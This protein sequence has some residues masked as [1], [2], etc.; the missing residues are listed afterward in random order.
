MGDEMMENNSNDRNN[1]EI[2]ID[3]VELYGELKKNIKFIFGVTAAC[4]AAAAI[5][6]F[7]IAKPVYGYTTIIQMPAVVSSL[8]INGFVEV[9][10]DDIDPENKALNKLVKAEVPRNTSVIKIYFEG[11]SNEKV[12]AFANAYMQKVMSNINDSIIERQKQQ[13]AVEEIKVIKEEINYINSRLRESSFSVEDGI[14]RLDYLIKRI[15]DK[16]NNQILLKAV[17]ANEAKMQEE[18]IRP[19]KLRNILIAA[20]AGCFLSCCYVIFKYLLNRQ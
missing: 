7:A 5:Y 6:S 13:F 18:P 4:I 20:V 1:N 10:K 2:E 3:L 19:K 8:Q 16:E 12:E 11:E 9:I 17:V 14:G 15:E